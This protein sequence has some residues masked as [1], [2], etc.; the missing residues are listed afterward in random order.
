M[1]KYSVIEWNEKTEFS[2]FNDIVME[3][4]KLRKQRSLCTRCSRPPVVCICA[5]LPASTIA[6]ETRVVIVQHPREARKR[7][8]GSVP[9]IQLVLGAACTVVVSDV[10]RFG[11]DE[12]LDEALGEKGSGRTVLLFPG[13][14]STPLDAGGASSTSSTTTSSS[15]SGVVAA[16]AAA[17]A[18]SGI[19]TLLLVDGTWR[20]ANKMVRS[21]GDCLDMIPRVMFAGE[22]D[23][24]FGDLRKEPRKHC[25]STLEAA[26]QA[27]RCLE[28][29]RG[30]V[31]CDCL[32][33]VFA[34]AV[35]QQLA[36]KEAGT[37][38]LPPRPPPKCREGKQQQK[39]KTGAALPI[40][41]PSRNAL[42]LRTWALCTTKRDATDA[43]SFCTVE[44]LPGLLTYADARTQCGERNVG[45]RRGERYCVRAVEK[46]ADAVV[47]EE[48]EEEEEEE[49][50]AKT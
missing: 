50:V 10:V 37:R 33:T 32:L 45:R 5:A 39:K 23:G 34:H 27:L 46:D 4:L 42:V 26:A 36:Q 14:T 24:M 7:I 1:M 3:T 20:Q 16:V 12:A 49:H 43:V 15:S 48:E 41:G 47:V 29:T 13:A 9:L 17:P 11:L 30:G 19:A 2:I 18:T 40:F 38:H 6:I 21:S 31:A 44:I 28:P 22:V 35:A 8:V 25:V